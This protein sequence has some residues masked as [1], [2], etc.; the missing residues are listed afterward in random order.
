MSAMP[1]GHKICTSPLTDYDGNALGEVTLYQG[2][3]RPGSR[4]II[5]RDKTGL[6]LFDTDDC[7][8]HA[9]AVNKFEFW[10]ARYLGPNAELR[11]LF[12]NGHV[13][14]Q[15]SVQYEAYLTWKEEQDK[16]QTPV[17][18]FELAD[19]EAAYRETGGG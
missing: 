5:A 3:Y 2:R 12:D 1:T 9:N 13:P 19:I 14:A 4:R 16:V 10:L 15:P 8:D 17:Q 11:R 6:V 7:F 18:P